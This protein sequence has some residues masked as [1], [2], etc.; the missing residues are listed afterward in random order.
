MLVPARTMVDVPEILGELEEGL[1]EAD[2]GIGSS[3]EV[4]YVS[5][6]GLLHTCTM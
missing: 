6:R 2:F 4:R 5:V 1:P 3:D